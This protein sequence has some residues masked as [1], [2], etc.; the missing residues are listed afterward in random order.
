MFDKVGLSWAEHVTIAALSVALVE[1]GQRDDQDA[2][3]WRIAA[4][5][6]LLVIG[7]LGAFLKIRSGE[8][9]ALATL[10]VLLVVIRDVPP[11]KTF[12]GGGGI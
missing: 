11:G 10:A 5:L 7:I 1:L 3:S 2:A 6:M 4:L 9:V 8:L 12:N